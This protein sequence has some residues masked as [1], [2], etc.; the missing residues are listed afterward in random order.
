MVKILSH[1]DYLAYAKCRNV[2]TEA[3]IIAKFSFERNLIDGVA[4]NPK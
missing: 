1:S 3:V 4:S 2:S